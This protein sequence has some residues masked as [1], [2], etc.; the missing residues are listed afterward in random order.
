MTKFANGRTPAPTFDDDLIQELADKIVAL[1]R[2]AGGR[3]MRLD[4]EWLEDA[5]GGRLARDV[6]RRAGFRRLPEQ[7]AVGQGNSVP[8]EY[9]YLVVF[10]EDLEDI[11]DDYRPLAA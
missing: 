11:V 10:A 8:G 4:F 5:I 1:A 6:L 9:T 2:R 7:W 3:G